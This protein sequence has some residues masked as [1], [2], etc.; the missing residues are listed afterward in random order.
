MELQQRNLLKD[1]LEREYRIRLKTKNENEIHDLINEV[2]KQPKSMDVE[3]ELSKRYS[4]IT[5]V[6][7]RAHKI[8]MDL[9]MV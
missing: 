7:L 1:R 5:D 3:Q 6:S 2:R 4:L 8:L 9:K